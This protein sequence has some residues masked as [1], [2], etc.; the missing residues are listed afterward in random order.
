VRK[1]E[2]L[3]TP[4]RHGAIKVAFIFF[5]KTKIIEIEVQG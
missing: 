2:K 4:V 3:V 5:E 1:V